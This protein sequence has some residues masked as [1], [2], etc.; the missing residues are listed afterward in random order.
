MTAETGF[1][2]SFMNLNGLLKLI[3]LGISLHSTHVILFIDP[4]LCRHCEKH[5]KDYGGYKDF[6]RD[7][8]NLGDIWDDLSPVRHKKYKHRG[9]NELPLEIPRRVVQISGV[10]GGVLVDP[11]GGTGGSLIASLE[12][13]MKFVACDSQLSYCD[14]VFLDPPFNLLTLG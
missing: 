1:I 3:R 2:F 13:K 4:Q 11:F 6:V 10:R 9:P 8:I 7:G 12:G 14:I 5:V